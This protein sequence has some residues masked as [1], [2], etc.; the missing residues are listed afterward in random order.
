VDTTRTLVEAMLTA[1]GGPG[2]LVNGSAQAYY[3]DRGE[4][5]LDETAGPGTG[6]LSELT[7]QWEAA[8]QP[9]VESDRIRVVLVR[10]GLVL[11]PSGPLMQ[12]LLP[13]IRLGV[14][15]PLGTGRQ[16]WSWITLADEVAGI[17]HVM[18]RDDVH[19]PVNFSA[20]GVARNVEVIRAIAARWSRPALLPAPGFALRIVVGGFADEILASTR[21]IPAALEAAGFTFAHPHLDSA[22]EW[23]RS[24]KA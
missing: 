14:A 15:G 8:A 5:G 17:E 22:T 7:Q 6:F 24:E 19:G 21:M 23:L 11:G 16:W 3:G 4:E 18:G 13:L 12:R 1:D 20:P 9:A 10:T 2:V